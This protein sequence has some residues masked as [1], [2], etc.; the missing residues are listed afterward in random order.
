[1]W[2][3]DSFLRNLDLFLKLRH[4]EEFPGCPHHDLVVC[5]RNG[6]LIVQIRS[7]RHV[8]SVVMLYLSR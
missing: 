4:V 8:A 3:R 7:D 1:M 2:G 5:W 6:E